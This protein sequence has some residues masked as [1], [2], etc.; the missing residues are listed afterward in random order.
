MKVVLLDDWEKNYIGHPQL[1]RL[2]Q[3]FEVEL[4]HD[5]PSQ[6]ELARR[7]SSAHVVIPIRERTR[8]NQAVLQS[9]VSTKLIA[10][11][12]S[13]VAHIDME[14]AKRLGI[15]VVTTPG[16]AGGV[17][18][19]VLGLM[20]VYA[21]QLVQLNEALHEGQWPLSVGM[22]L[23]GK[24]IGII[25]LG[26]IGSGVAKVAKVLGMRVLAWG[27]RLTEERAQEQGVQYATLEDLLQASDVISLHV[28]LVPATRSMI[29]AEHFS[30][31]KKKA[32]FIN[33][34]RG[35]L[36]DEAALVQALTEQ[37]IGGAG[38][39][40]FTNEPLGAGHP[41]VG[42]PNVI[43][44]PHIGWKTDE[45]FNRFLTVSVDN[46]FSHFRIDG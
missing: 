35:E 6:E 21:R 17:I 33:T 39:D 10:Q 4:Y 40:V 36:V 25:G 19:L 11:T 43:L 7:L 27:P 45:M 28:R 23:E 44:T 16:G 26:H 29:R 24:T 34:S 18:E 22:S 15:S 20:V 1:E 46:I 42:L 13:G 14:E 5:A 12:G 8:F 37:R 41:F 30:L 3:H 38:L 31:M 9:M 2:R 32:F